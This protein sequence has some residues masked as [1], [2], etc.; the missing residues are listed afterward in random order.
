MTPVEWSVMLGKILGFF[1]LIVAIA[2]LMSLAERKISA[3][4]QLRYGPNRVGPWGILQPLA[5]G[6]KFIFKEEVVPDGANPIL[7]KMAPAMA[8]APAMMTVA[9]VPFTFPIVLDGTE[10]PMSIAHLDIGVLFFLAMGS[11]AV[12]GVLIG[13]W[14]SN[15][16][17][18]LLGGLRSSA[19]MVSYELAMILAAI[20]V[21]ILAGSMNLSEIYASQIPPEG[22]GLWEWLQGS[23]IVFRFPVGTIAFVIFLIAAFA[24]T[25]RHPFDLAECETELVGG[26]HTEF[27]AMRF[28]LFFIGEY[29]A[30]ATMSALIVTFFLGGP[31]LFGV[32]RSMEPTWLRALAGFGVFLAKISFFLFLYIWVRWTLPRFRWDQLMALGWKVLLPAA[33]V[34]VALAGALVVWAGY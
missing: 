24:E 34:N 13:G 33:L 12:Y 31:S 21:L 7:F 1:I 18:S 6:L 32:V 11:L 28:T 2:A 10:F 25:N 30:M 22:A 16:K 5:D 20:C 17:Y 23:W 15:S 29:A 19:Q 4:I 3:W 9:V 8:A 26:F 27:S 14:A